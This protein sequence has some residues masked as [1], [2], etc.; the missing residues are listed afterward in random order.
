MEGEGK[1]GE[2]E[3][4]GKREGGEEREDEG[5]GREGERQGKG[6]VFEVSGFGSCLV[7]FVTLILG[8]EV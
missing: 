2:R 8:A 4:G 1:R 5:K 7:A 6:C 3:D